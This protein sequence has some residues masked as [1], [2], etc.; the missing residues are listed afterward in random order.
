MQKPK[1]KLKT[2]TRKDI[3][4][5]AGVSETVVS[6]VTNG[7]RYVK[8]EKRQR[9]LQAIEELNYRPNT[10]ARALKGKNSHHILFIAD[11]ITGEY[12]GKLI[13]EIDQLLYPQDYFISL[14]ADRADEDFVNRIYSHFFDGIIIGSATFPISSIQRLIDAKVPV[15]LLEI[16]DYSSIQGVHAL[17]N[18][19]LYA[20]A[21]TAVSTLY[22]RGRRKLLLVDRYNPDGNFSGDD[23]W[24]LKGFLA[25]CAEKGI[26]GTTLSG[27]A[28]EDE[29]ID[30]LVC[31]LAEKGEV[32]G[33]V[34]RTDQVA[35]LALEAAKRAGRTVPTDLSVI[36][37]DN[38][39]LARFS[40]PKLSS[41]AVSQE[42]TASA[43]V[44][45]LM[46]LI[47]AKG[48]LPARIEQYLD[49]EL[50]MRESV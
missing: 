29:L 36:G 40:T 2:I 9:V 8:A 13:S 34:G 37:F 48:S 33:I 18:T 31:L 16:R 45:L 46:Q 49:M 19:G 14:C 43:I 44:K 15:V 35:L 22:E 50:I 25:A 4:R 7:N 27:C 42:I 6:Y 5:A 41:I 20:G 17:V 12:F 32:D 24:R 10:M 21:Q 23:D 11:D 30:Q 39:R 26:V 47:E 38:S 28:H 1:K 3:A